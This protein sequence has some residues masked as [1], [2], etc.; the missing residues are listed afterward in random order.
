[1]RGGA[2]LSV[3]AFAL[4]LWHPLDFPWVV[5]DLGV[6]RPAGRI[7]RLLEREAD[8]APAPIRLQHAYSE[9]LADLDDILGVLDVLPGQFRDVQQPL[10]AVAD[11]EEGAVLFGAG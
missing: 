6:F 2:Y 9:R 1:M 7:L 11:L 3:D 8:P 4:G 10:D 5:R